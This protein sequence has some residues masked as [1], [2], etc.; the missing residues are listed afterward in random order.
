GIILLMMFASANREAVTN[1]S[2][3]LIEWNQK[4]PVIAC[5]VSPPGVW[6]RQVADLG[7]AGAI[8]NLPTPERAAKVMAG[9]YQYEKLVR[10]SGNRSRVQR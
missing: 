5:L 9:L 2:D 1:I 8:F 4:K 6:D 3:L 10:E 7:K